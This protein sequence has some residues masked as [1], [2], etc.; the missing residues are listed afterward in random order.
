MWEQ[1]NKHETDVAPEV[2]TKLA[3]DLT[4]KMWEIAN[5]S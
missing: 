1:H 5:V 4:Y 3:E 2:Y